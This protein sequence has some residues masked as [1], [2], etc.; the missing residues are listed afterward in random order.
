[1]TFKQQYTFKQKQ[2]QVT[3]YFEFQVAKYDKLFVW[4]QCPVQSVAV[5]KFFFI[6]VINW[7]FLYLFLLAPLE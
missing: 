7:T 2:A 6:N 4:V 5:F 1:M 3:E